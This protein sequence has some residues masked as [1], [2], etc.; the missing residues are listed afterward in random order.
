MWHQIAHVILRRLCTCHLAVTCHP[1]GSVEFCDAWR[2]KFT[3]ESE[4]GEAAWIGNVAVIRTPHWIGWCSITPAVG[5]SCAVDPEATWPGFCPQIVAAFRPIF[6]VCQVLHTMQCASVQSEGATL[7]LRTTPGSNLSDTAVVKKLL[8]CRQ[9][10][11]Q[12]R[13]K[14]LRPSRRVGVSWTHGLS[15]L[16]VAVSASC[17]A[18]TVLL[19]PFSSRHDRNHLDVDTVASC[20]LQGIVTFN[21]C[22]PHQHLPH[23]ACQ[24]TQSFSEWTRAA[25]Q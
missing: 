4:I 25:A 21:I 11:R 24:Q 12:S 9:L 15:L 18:T 17:T 22:S 1:F 7:G 8:V 6:S 14:A 16:P 10:Q 13:R 3:G 19:E 20:Q 5:I 23:C 2:S